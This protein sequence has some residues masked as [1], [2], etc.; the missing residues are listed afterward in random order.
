VNNLARPADVRYGLTCLAMRWMIVAALAALLGAPHARA[1]DSTARVGAGGLVLQKT[2]DIR[3]LSE[4]LSISVQ[5]IEVE[6]RFRND[7]AR[8]IDTVVAF[9]MPEFHWDPEQDAAWRNIGP[10]E[11]FQVHVDG[12]PAAVRA[13]RKALLDGRD[14]T[15]QLRKAGLKDE[16]I[17]RTFG[18]ALDTGGMALP[19]PVVARLQAMGA[20]EGRMPRWKVAETAYWNQ[21]FPPGKEVVV[22]HS[23]RPFAGRIF[24]SYSTQWPPAAQSVPLSSN[25]DADRACMDEGGMKAVLTKARQKMK[26]GAGSGYIN[27]NDVE[28]ILGTGRN[29]KG[30]IADFTLDIIKERPQDVVSLCFPGKPERIGDRTLRFRMHDYVPQDRLLLNFYSVE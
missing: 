15:A 28:Y 1:N 11:S 27:L 18:A 24:G 3:M 29:W 9:P 20:S 30:S 13:E 17:F 2:D 14:I 10:V 26:D 4:H 12:K 23:Y 22:T 25:G 7:S 16:E 5:R 8:A 6:Y 19:E 21:S